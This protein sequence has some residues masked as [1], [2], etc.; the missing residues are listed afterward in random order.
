MD[1]LIKLG[2]LKNHVLEAKVLIIIFYGVGIT[3]ISI[4][5]TFP[6]FQRLIP[7]ALLFSFGMLLFFHL[8]KLNLK[9]FLVLSSIFLLGLA[10]EIAGVSTGIIF[11]HYEYGDSLGVKIFHTPVII[12]M[13]WLL[14]TYIT[15]SVF[16]KFDI[17]TL[18][19]IFAASC[20]MLLYDI[21]LEQVAPRLDMW[22]WKNHSVPIRN[23]VAW[24][25]LALLF[26][27]LL[28]LFNIKTQNPLA[29][30]FLIAQLLFFIILY[31]LL[32]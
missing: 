31:Y 2:K 11:G 12:G 19:K 20:T 25:I 14:L 8:E 4:D 1:I 16:E 27:A 30:T 28:K 13:N 5:Y 22:H 32:K 15:S 7:Y 26:Q 10:I 18:V 24:F 17:R 21:I 6:F 23:Y 29:S 3:G 9:T